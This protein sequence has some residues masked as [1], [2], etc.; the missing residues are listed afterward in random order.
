MTKRDWIVFQAIHFALIDSIDELTDEESA[1]LFH[2]KGIYELTLQHLN[3]FNDATYLEEVKK[4]YKYY[5]KKIM[6]EIEKSEVQREEVSK[7]L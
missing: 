5:A 7:V 6:K 4:V 2:D 1:E 3:Q